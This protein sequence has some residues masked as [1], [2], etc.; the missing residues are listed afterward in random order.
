VSPRPR[1]ALQ[2][3]TQGETRSHSKNSSC[4]QSMEVRPMA[5]HRPP[6]GTARRPHPNVDKV[7]KHSSM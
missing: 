3:A 1:S 2:A 4:S 5:P 6:S 7:K